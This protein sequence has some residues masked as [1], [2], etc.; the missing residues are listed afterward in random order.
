MLLALQR[1]PSEAGSIYL[2]ALEQIDLQSRSQA[3]LARKVLCWLVL[4]KSSLTVPELLEALAIETDSTA[5]D[6]LNRTSAAMLVK[7]CRGLVVV[8]SNSKII[9]LA[10]LTV[11][12]F[13]TNNLSELSQMK[14]EI[15]IACV[16]YISF[17]AFKT[18][19]CNGAH[20]FGHRLN[21][22]AFY[23]YACAHCSEHLRDMDPTDRALDCGNLVKFATSKTLSESYFQMLFSYGIN[24]YS[25]LY[26]AQTTPL[27]VAAALGVG[28]LAHLLLQQYSSCA[29]RQ[30]SHACTPLL[31]AIELGHE[32]VVEAFLD[33]GVDT[34]GETESPLNCAARN[35]RDG[36]VRLLFEKTMA[37]RGQHRKEEQDLFV[38]AIVGDL[39]AITKS[40]QLG[41]NINVTDIDGGTV[42]QWASWYGHVAVVSCLLAAGSEIEAEDK[43]G[44]RAL[45][46][47]A[48]RG[49]DDVVRVLLQSGAAINAKDSFGFTPLLRAAIAKTPA[50][51][52]TLLAQ[53]ADLSSVANDGYSALDIAIGMGRVDNVRLLLDSGID[54]KDFQVS[55]IRILEP[56][57]AQQRNQILQMISKA[58]RL[59][60]Y[61]ES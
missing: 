27:H 31:R 16:A 56:I 8:D 44:R 35:R 5:L 32:S 26:P 20:A 49:R 43:N 14:K 48:E 3:Q 23:H 13:L 55:K 46:E 38:A 60:S 52:S 57:T 53:G 24:W 9:R 51:A 37:C 17:D 1:L 21:Q 25:D 34:E 36:I 33:H 2:Q 59:H 12:E 29:N 22:Y 47:A 11:H 19:P 6:P 30:D 42:L 4:A 40:I 61:M 28:E 54:V 45:H 39:E 18:G 7:A 41:A 58:Q 50:V 15:A 10:H